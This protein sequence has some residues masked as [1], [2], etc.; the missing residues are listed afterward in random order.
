[1]K[2]ENK[3][4]R[5]NF[6]IKSSSLHNSTYKNYKKIPV[7]KRRSFYMNLEGISNRKP[8]KDLYFKNILSNNNIYK[9]IKKIHK[10]K[11]NE[12]FNKKRLEVLFKFMFNIFSNIMNIISVFNYILQ[13]FFDEDD[14]K[15]EFISLGLNYV[16][17]SLT[18]YFL[19]EYIMLALQ[20]KWGYFKNLISIDSF[21]DLITIVPSIIAYFISFKGVKLNFIRIFRI[22]RVFRV[23]RIYKSLRRIQNESAQDYSEN[24]PSQ[25]TIKLN[26]IKL[27][28]FT[29]VVILV[30][31]FFIGAGLVLGLNDIIEKAFS[32]N[33]FNFL[34][35][36]YFMIVTFSTLGYGDILPTNPITKLSVIIGLFCLIIIVSNQITKL[37][38][39]LKFWGPGISA[40]HGQNH[41]IIIA[42]KTID[43]NMIIN[44][45]A[46]RIPIKKDFIIISKDIAPFYCTF[47]PYNRT[48]VI[49][50]H[51][52]DLEIMDLIN[53]KSASGVFIF[54]S[55]Y[56]NKYEQYD[57]ITDFFLMKFYQ[58]NFK[59]KLF[60]QTLNSEK[61]LFNPI[62]KNLRK[63]VPIWKMKSLIIAKSSFNEGFATFIQNLLF[64]YVPRSTDF[65]D[66]S[67]I[68]KFY[69][70]GAENKI[71]KHK[72]SKFFVGK[73]FFD[74]MYMIYFKSISD[75]FY[76]INI[77]Y[78]SIKVFLLIGVYEENITDNYSEDDIQIFPNNYELRS[79]SYGIFI[80]PFKNLKNLEEILTKFDTINEFKYTS[81]E[82]KK[83]SDFK[84]EEESN[85]NSLSSTYKEY[86]KNSCIYK[87]K[88][89]K[90]NG[91]NK[92]NSSNECDSSDD[93][94]TE[95][96]HIF[97]KS[98]KKVSNKKNSYSTKFFDNLS[99]KQN[100][101]K[102]KFSVINQNQKEFNLNH[103][104]KK[105]DKIFDSSNY[106]KENLNKNSA[107]Y[108]KK[109]LKKSSTSINR[110]EQYDN[111]K[112]NFN[113]TPIIREYKSS[114]LDTNK[115]FIKDV[116]EVY[117]KIN[118]EMN[119]NILNQDK[120]FNNR[121]LNINLNV[122][123]FLNNNN[124][125]KISEENKEDS[126][127]FNT[128]ND[129]S[130]IYTNNKKLKETDENN[131]FNF[132][133]S[134]YKKKSKVNQKSDENY[135]NNNEKNNI[136]SD[137]LN[138]SKRKVKIDMSL[139]SNKNISN[140][141]NAKL[142]KKINRHNKN[143]INVKKTKN[144]SFDCFNEKTNKLD[145]LQIMDK[146]NNSNEGN[147]DNYY[148]NIGKN[149]IL[150]EN[151]YNEDIKSNVEI[152]NLKKNFN[153]KE[154]ISNSFK[155]KLLKI[156][157][158]N[159]NNK[160]VLNNDRNDDEFE[161][162]LQKFKKKKFSLSENKE[163]LTKKI[164]CKTNKKIN[165]EIDDN[166]RRSLRNQ[167]YRLQVFTEFSNFQ[168]KKF[169]NKNTA[170]NLE[171]LNEIDNETLYYFSKENLNNLSNKFYS[172]NFLNF[173]DTIIPSHEFIIEHR[174]HDIEKFNF[175]NSFEDHIIIVG[176]QDILYQL[177]KLLFAHNET[178]ICLITRLDYEDDNILKLLKQYSNLRYFRGETNN[179]AHLIN[180]GLN[181]AS[182]VIFLTEK[183]N[184]KTKEDMD[185]LLIYK[186]IDHFF[187]TK[188]LIEIWDRNN[189][190][191]LGYTPLIK[192][193]VTEKNEFLHPCFMAGRIVY[194][195]HLDNIISNCYLNEVETTAWMKILSLGIP[196]KTNKKGNDI[197][198][199][200]EKNYKKSQGIPIILTIDIP[201]QY[202]EKEYYI[203]I[204]D[205]MKLEPPALSLGIY[206][207]QPLNYNFIKSQGEI[208]KKYRDTNSGNS[209]DIITSHK[210]KLINKLE[211]DNDE[212]YQEKLKIMK[213]I[214]YNDKVVMDIMDL[215]KNYLP[216]FITNPPPNF[217]IADN[218]KVMILY[219]TDCDNY[220]NLDKKTNNTNYD[221]LLNNK[222]FIE[223]DLLREIHK[224]REKNKTDDMKSMHK[225][226][227]EKLRIKQ[228]KIL[229]SCNL[230]KKK[231]M[232]IF[233]EK[234]VNLDNN[235][236][237]SSIRSSQN[238][239][240]L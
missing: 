228:E 225:L 22:F 58:K 189:T 169:R 62:Y 166:K 120:Y 218:C 91:S 198:K 134:Y 112:Q 49:N 83:S 219:N 202:V 123:T 170:L 128:E 10:E 115:I 99:E 2:N 4:L 157:S 39:L 25:K 34:D 238:N 8:R 30:C 122:N 54:S 96:N 151:Y 229:T 109:I 124:F 60:I 227:K 79:S 149:L 47:Y 145:S 147:N 36:I 26:P 28:F 233:N 160:R 70:Y 144:L 17:L 48:N 78:D 208:K 159:N 175:K 182:M 72:L 216:I 177:L 80:G 43:V 118:L 94:E 131:S 7:L 226:K 52:I 180:A 92:S 106:V 143:T 184:E 121:N 55:K 190:K 154:N 84:D 40:F 146:E 220:E 33:K 125:P 224:I 56:L 223:N 142:T 29:I 239:Y 82:D 194:S 188:L 42:D 141:E 66:Y 102:A 195:G 139:T 24:S 207:K 20:L 155:N 213:D 136:S 98:N 3:R 64:N 211:I 158:Q 186:T 171:F 199:N 23:L 178:D 16:E 75:Y 140:E 173:R 215:N 67:N 133:T 235:E 95:K 126:N 231:I 232:K 221:I 113:Q 100:K 11:Q 5:N 214:S 150:N 196:N 174:I 205:L 110:V 204:D 130:I 240:N 192:N 97:S 63:V 164:F 13:T 53:I 129:K 117:D 193:G 119:I 85:N 19:I 81:Y 93:S 137:S 90:Y 103:D 209:V 18:F 201:L 127:H 77:E 86:F 176:Y 76:K 37:A 167:N 179:P 9:R 74:A 181:K 135:V 51:N 172:K 87:K 31:V 148:Y 222:N 132:N 217:I 57:K 200:Y 32:K 152:K 45:L 105:V 203:L 210:K 114:T 230:L 21:I 68:I 6:R 183:I 38:N 88:I 206:V 15:N 46:T 162:H 89:H 197:K 163:D 191:F 237:I 14:P 168:V 236:S 156:S 104:S 185:N 27:Q 1:M 69:L 107:E 234:F 50:I 108:Y 138:N 12:E 161:N 44:F 65:Q 212:G 73:N 165:K 101:S 61:T 111:I 35:A 59:A 153:R 71:L 187:N 41:I 116:K